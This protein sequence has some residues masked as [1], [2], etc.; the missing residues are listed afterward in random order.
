MFKNSL[1]LGKFFPCH[2]GHLYLIDTAI[3]QSEMVHVIMTH[4]L[5]Q[6]IP[7]EV[8][9]EALNAIYGNNPKVKIYSV[10]D[11]G[12]PQYDS[13]CETLDQ[14]YSYW[15]P[16]VYNQVEELDAVFTSEDYGDDFARYLGVKHIL[17]D[18]ERSKVPVS[19]TLVRSNPFQ[20]WDFIPEPM[21]PHFVKRIVIMGPESC[22]KST[23]TQNLANHYQTN[24][25][26][27]YGR[28]V[29]ENNGGVTIDDFI[30]ISKGR[31]DLEDWMI[32]NSNKLL[33]CDTEDITTYLFSKMFYPDEYYKVEE[34]FK[35]ALNSKPK[36]D[37][38]ILLSPDCDAV[39]DG[40]RQFLDDRWEHY[41]MIKNELVQSQCNFVEIGGDWDNRFKESKKLINDLIY[42]EKL[43]I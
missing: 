31:Q 20:Y 43:S 4:N 32:K 36:Y 13:E 34:Y 7:G 17:V 2:L 25:V 1:V 15:V 39:Q 27:E 42:T 16:L 9:F 12:L 29:Y 26:I 24:F 19:G 18:K 37:L 41:D 11:E 28:L 14:F 21:K 40:T 3:S 35:E 6:S 8:R 23:L 38:Y 5:S 33:F 30:P 10:S 22:G